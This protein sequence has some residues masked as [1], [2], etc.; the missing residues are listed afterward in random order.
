VEGRERKRERRARAENETSKKRGR[1]PYRLEAFFTP[2]KKW[3]I[4]PP[5]L[6][7]PAP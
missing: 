3:E 7:I 2:S 4:V 6:P 1:R 5:R